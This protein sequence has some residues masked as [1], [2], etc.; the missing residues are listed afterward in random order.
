MSPPSGP[1]ASSAA[2]I[3]QVTP[4]RLTSTSRR[5]CSDESEARIPS[6]P[7]PALFTQTASRPCWAATEARA[8]WE[9]SSRTSWVTA[10]AAP[11][12]SAVRRTRSASMS[13]AT[14]WYPRRTNLDAI[15]LPIPRPAPVTTADSMEET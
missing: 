3:P 9:A 7:T 2:R 14:T 12:S 5:T 8:W 10:S 13:A 4:S 1:N 15:A 6:S 11:I